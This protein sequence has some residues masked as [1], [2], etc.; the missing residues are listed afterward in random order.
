MS[1]LNNMHINQTAILA[2]QIA[3][4]RQIPIR[5]FDAAL[6]KLLTYINNLKIVYDESNT[7]KVISVSGHEA[8]DHWMLISTT[9]NGRQIDEL[10][11]K[12]VSNVEAFFK[13]Y[14]LAHDSL[15]LYDSNDKA[16]ASLITELQFDGYNLLDIGSDFIN[17]IYD[18][19]IVL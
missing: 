3:A 19:G 18:G 12:S 1:T 4:L 13:E 15:I 17:V 11:D 6:T 9:I 5:D 7:H 10:F 2:R 14:G 16:I 8:I